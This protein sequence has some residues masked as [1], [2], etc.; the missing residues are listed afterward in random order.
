MKDSVIAKLV[1]H[2]IETPIFL[3]TDFPAVLVVENP[4]EFYDFVRELKDQFEGEDG[5]FLLLREEERLEFP[6]FGEMICDPFSIDFGTKLFQSVLYKSL[7]KIS[8]EDEFHLLFQQLNTSFAEYFSAL[9]DRLPIA[10]TFDEA[11]I[12]GV[13]KAGNV[14]IQKSYDGFLDM[15]LCYINAMTALKNVRFFVFVHL[16]SV[17]SAEELRL[18]YRHCALEKVGLLLI[19]NGVAKE[20]IEEERV[21]IITED[22]CEILDKNTEKE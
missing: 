10:L 4:H 6:R 1:H 13:L 5:N 20:V 11:D 7:E 15:I 21:L 22:L 8:R 19:E 16:K 3:S 17:L 14:R 9:F 18:L 2:R 12:S